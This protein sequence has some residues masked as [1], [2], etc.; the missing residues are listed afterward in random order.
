MDFEAYRDVWVFI[1]GKLVMDL[2]GL[3]SKR[4]Q[5][6]EI[7]RLPGLKDGRTYS[8]KIFHAER[9]TTQSNFKMETT[10]QLRRVEAPQIHGMFD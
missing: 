2:G 6:L 8:L 4:E 10:L 5:T 3:H 1:D 7:N 9:H